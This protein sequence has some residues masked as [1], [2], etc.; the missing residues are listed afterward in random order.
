VLR[1]ANRSDC[2]NSDPLDGK[3]PD[4]SR[5]SPAGD[6]RQLFPSRRQRAVAAEDAAHQYKRTADGT[7]R[8]LPAE[9]DSRRIVYANEGAARQSGWLREA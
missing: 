6:A 9:P 5:R 4:R 8:D 2:V 7:G 1:A 3:H